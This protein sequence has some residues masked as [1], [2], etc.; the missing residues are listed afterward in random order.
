MVKRREGV[1]MPLPDASANHWLKYHYIDDDRKKK[2]D[3]MM[4]F[5]SCL[6]ISSFVGKFE[7]LQRR[8]K[9]WWWRWW[10]RLSTGL[11]NILLYIKCQSSFILISYWLK[12]DH[13]KVTKFNC[14]PHEVCEGIKSINARILMPG[15][16]KTGSQACVT[17][18]PMKPK[19]VLL[20]KVYF[21]FKILFNKNSFCLV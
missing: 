9:T 17:F 14:W 5:I 1:A 11:Y 10:Y 20:C 3:L 13:V 16:D 8:V 12:E 2:G 21:V 7:C 4:M 15:G 6:F 19:V 18:V